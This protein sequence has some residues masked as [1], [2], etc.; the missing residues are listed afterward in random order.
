MR[1]LYT[2]TIQTKSQLQLVKKGKNG[3][4]HNPKENVTIFDH[5]I[6]ALCYRNSVCLVY[7]NLDLNLNEINKWNNITLI[8]CSIKLK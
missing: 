6:N 8:L 2:C 7:I 4:K 3:K 5:S 1:M